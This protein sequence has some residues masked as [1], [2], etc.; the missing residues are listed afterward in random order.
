MSPAIVLVT[1]ARGNPG[2]F[3][4]SIRTQKLVARAA[5]T[6]VTTVLRRVP[7]PHRV[8]PVMYSFLSLLRERDIGYDSGRPPSVKLHTPM[9]RW[10]LMMF[11]ARAMSFWRLYKVH[12]IALCLK[13]RECKIANDEVIGVVSYVTYG[14]LY[15]KYRTNINLHW[16]VN[17]LSLLFTVYQSE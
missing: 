9:C 3:Y 11:C 2:D 5:Y 12:F 8:A 15:L 1:R 14:Q 7:A 6:E 13:S 4:S 16:Y 10:N 17:F